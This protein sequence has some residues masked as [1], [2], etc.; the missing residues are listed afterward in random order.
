MPPGYRERFTEEE[1]A[2]KSKVWNGPDHNWLR[3]TRCLKSMKLLGMEFA[4]KSFLEKLVD[5]KEKH[6]TISFNTFK[7]WIDA[8]N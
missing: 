8:V 1:I 6:P 5:L 2:K 4:A 7:Y 3:I